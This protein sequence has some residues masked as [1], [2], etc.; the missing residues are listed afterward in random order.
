[1]SHLRTCLI[2]REHARKLARENSVPFERQ[3][4]IPVQTQK[5]TCHLPSPK[6]DNERV[7]L[8]A[9]LLWRQLRQTSSQEKFAPSLM[10]VRNSRLGASV[11]SVD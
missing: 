4:N 7:I 11:Q 10:H 6:K 1:M 8:P 5:S 3:D 9:S 2:S